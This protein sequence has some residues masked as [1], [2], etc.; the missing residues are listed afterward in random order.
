MREKKEKTSTCASRKESEVEVTAEGKSGGVKGKNGILPKR[1][2]FSRGIPARTRGEGFTTDPRGRMGGNDVISPHIVERES[3]GKR[4]ELVPGGRKTK[5]TVRTRGR[6]GRRRWRRRSKKEAREKKKTH[7]KGVKIAEMTGKKMPMITSRGTRRPKG[8][9][10]LLLR[11]TTPARGK[12]LRNFKGEEGS[13]STGFATAPGTGT[14]RG[15][16]RTRHDQ[17][18]GRPL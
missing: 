16:D 6:R 17:G 4:T 11:E 14:T 8:G 2:K 1:R 10:L 18:R 13:L 7:G 3:R 15:K 5:G 9:E 12:K